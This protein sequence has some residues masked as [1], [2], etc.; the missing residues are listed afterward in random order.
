[1]KVYVPSSDVVNLKVGMQ[2]ELTTD[3][4]KGRIYPGKIKLIN[5]RID[6]ETGTV[7]VTVEVYDKTHT[8]K[9]G[10]FVETK[11]LIRKKEDAIVIPVKG[12]AFIKGKPYVFA[13]N[14]GQVIQ[15]AVE[16]GITEGDKIE[17]LSGIEAGERVVTVGVMGLE[18]K[19][20]VRVKR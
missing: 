12:V 18:D 4:L 11:I 8:L 7:K 14:R 13:F 5:P 2:A 10:M 6:I 15:K 17:V 1:V 20:K 16:L 19:M 3:I 9:P